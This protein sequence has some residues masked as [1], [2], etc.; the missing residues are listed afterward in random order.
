MPFQMAM[1]RDPKREA[2]IVEDLG[3]TAEP[4]TTPSVTNPA[5]PGEEGIETA[6]AKQREAELEEM[7]ASEKI[8]PREPDNA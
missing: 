6:V 7:L 5:A 3:L 8:R 1:H 2:Q 4:D